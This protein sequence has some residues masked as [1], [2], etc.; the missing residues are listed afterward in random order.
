MAIM[1]TIGQS[2][3]IIIN[4]FIN[5]APQNE[6]PI[7]A[8]II[9]NLDLAIAS[10]EGAPAGTQ[11]D[12]YE[13]PQ[14]Q[15]LPE[16]SN[17]EFESRVYDDNINELAQVPSTNE[18]RT[19]RRFVIEVTDD[20]A[21]VYTSFT[22]GIRVARATIEL[23]TAG[24]IFGENQIISNWTLTQS[25]ENFTRSP[26][27][28]AIASNNPTDVI[29]EEMP[30]RQRAVFTNDGELLSVGSITAT[31]IRQNTVTFSF[32]DDALENRAE[33][34]QD[35]TI[36]GLMS[37][38]IQDLA[39]RIGVSVEI[40]SDITLGEQE[41]SIEVRE[42]EPIIRAI[43]ELVRDAGVFMTR[44]S[45]LNYLI[46]GKYT[47]GDFAPAGE[48]TRISESEFA[49]FSMTGS[50][51]G[52]YGS[53]EIEMPD[54]TKFTI[55]LQ[56]PNS[57]LISRYKSPFTSQVTAEAQ[58]RRVAMEGEAMQARFRS[59]ASLSLGDVAILKNMGR[60]EVIRIDRITQRDRAMPFDY[61]GRCWSARLGIIAG[62]I[63]RAEFEVLFLQFNQAGRLIIRIA[64]RNYSLYS[65]SGELHQGD[66]I[67]SNNT[68]F[69]ILPTRIAII[70][71]NDSR[72]LFGYADNP[73]FAP[74]QPASEGL[75]WY[76][77]STLRIIAVL[78]MDYSTG[79]PIVT[80][81][82]RYYQ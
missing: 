27:S 33:F 22:Q 59:S 43:V 64:V 1:L 7:Q 72:I 21:I 67:Q 57:N 42:G 3:P 15:K 71:T 75:T 6:R 2:E 32:V 78:A 5:A 37:T 16:V 65:R 73:I 17:L 77:T 61:E 13:I 53:I 76:P 14:P 39:Q 74:T 54:K 66:E 41:I 38:A 52:I 60:D 24:L 63:E 31:S 68:Q 11:T 46:K 29:V 48:Y 35:E 40:E 26:S 20:Y 81:T 9:G 55:D 79:Q 51:S 82:E 56:N 36:S 34:T 47:H 58:A 62:T 10:I 49:D 44:T 69:I 50:A 23:A 19:A 45:H 12:D 25:L 80:N 4:Y 70:L 8:F 18:L 28:V 30:L